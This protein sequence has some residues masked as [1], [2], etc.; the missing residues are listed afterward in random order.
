MHNI[1]PEALAEALE[2]MITN[3]EA[4]TKMKNNLSEIDY[5][6][7]RAR[8]FNDWCKLLEA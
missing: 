4:R 1:T 8:Y 7:E 3:S 2:K 6:S 5:S